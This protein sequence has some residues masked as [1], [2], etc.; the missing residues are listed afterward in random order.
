V[1]A[2]I[3]E[4]FSIGLNA[5]WLEA[6]TDSTLDLNGDGT[7]DVLKGNRL[8]ITPEWKGSAWA[9]YTWPVSFMDAHGAYARLQWSYQ[10]DSNNILQPSVID[11]NPQI[12]NAAF[13]IAD[14]SVGLEADT[15]GLSLF[16]NNLTDERA[17]YTHLSGTMID[18]W[19][20]KSRYTNRPR[21][22]G[23]RFTKHVGD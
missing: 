8:P 2:L 7:F 4:N 20:V 16:I 12:R 15:W 23:I 5:Q 10:S 22:V 13:N 9:T 1:D 6:E 14:F 3:T 21:E 18:A 11:A 17:Q 19:N